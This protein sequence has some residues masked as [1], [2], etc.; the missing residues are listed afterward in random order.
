MFN[1]WQYR[2]LAVLL[3]V[4]CW[5]VVTGREKVDAWVE[6]PVELTNAPK[7]LYI[8]DGL[9]TRV[10]VRVRGPKSMVRSLDPKD[11]A[12]PLDLSGLGP[13]ENSIQLK[14]E[15][16]TV[17][18]ALEIMEV[19]PPRVTM[20]VEQIVEKNL[21]VEVRW[22]A[23]LDPNYELKRTAARPTMV[24]VRGPESAVS[25]LESVPTETV[26]VSSAKPGVIR[27]EVGLI[28]DEVIEA[29]P[30]EVG[31]TLVFGVKREDIWIK[32]PVTVSAP[33]GVQAEPRPATVQLE[34]N[35]PVTLSEID[36]KDA[37]TAE[38]RL[39]RDVKQVN[40]VFPYHVVLPDE[41]S[42]L[43]S[44]PERVEIIFKK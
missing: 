38:V 37:V 42:L 39:G 5:Y 22:E 43:K 24:A 29:G 19:S 30:S 35:K 18:N 11:L 40:D 32:I 4:V 26:D 15:N 2:I 36:L 27:S 23:S 6:I 41:V 21:P 3:A 44:V 7:D 13:G 25:G 14:P 20:K 16:V 17:S 33:E 10:D 12:Y 31:V 1:N 9:L 8:A 34:V 28:L